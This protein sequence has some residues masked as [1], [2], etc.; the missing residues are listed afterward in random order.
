MA[1]HSDQVKFHSTRLCIL[2]SVC[3][4]RGLS[5]VHLC[6]LVAGVSP[7]FTRVAYPVVYESRPGTSHKSSA[8]LLHSSIALDQAHQSA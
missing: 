4:G 8:K 6:L 5:G 1:V 2:P 7:S 3:H